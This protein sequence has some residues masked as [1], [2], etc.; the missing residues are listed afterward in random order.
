MKILPVPEF[1]LKFDDITV[2]LCSIVLSSNLFC[3]CVLI[4]LIPN[5]VKIE[6]HLHSEKKDQFLALKS[7]KFFH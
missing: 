2:L 6:C 7:E 1:E 5:S 4:L 3:K